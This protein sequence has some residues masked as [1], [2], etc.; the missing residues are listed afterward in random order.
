MD[1][2]G[3]HNSPQGMTVEQA[4]KLAAQTS[5][6]NEKELAKSFQLEAD[7]DGKYSLFGIEI[8]KSVA[9]ALNIIS[10][11]LI[12]SVSSGL[13]D[14]AYKQAKSAAKSFTPSHDTAHQAGIVAELV[15]RWGILFA[16]P[17]G[18]FVSAN[19]GYGRE[20]LKLRRDLK[21]DCDATGAD[22]S[23]NKVVNGVLRDASN[24]YTERLVLILPGMLSLVS[25]VPGAVISQREARAKREV[26]HA[27]TA[28]STA[29]EDVV[30]KRLTQVTDGLN[31]KLGE[32]KLKEE[33]YKLFAKNSNNKN[34]VYKILDAQY[35]ENHKDY[36]AN[37]EKYLRQWFD[38]NVWSEAL[39]HIKDENNAA[40][41]NKRTSY[42][43][44]KST[45]GNWLNQNM[46]FAG[47][48]STAGQGIKSS[49]QEEQKKKGKKPTAYALIYKLKE[50]MQGKP[51]K[52]EVHKEIMEIFQQVEEESGGVNKRFAKGLLE[53]LRDATDPVA[54]YI[55]DGRIDALSLIKLAG[56]EVV[57]DRKHNSRQFRKVEEIRKSLDEMCC[58]Q[59][60]KDN[61]ASQQE[62][63]GRFAGDQEHIKEAIKK[64]YNEMEA[65]QA[66][67]LFGAILP[68]EIL[69]KVVGLKKDDIRDLRKRA[70]EHIYKEV[71][72]SVILIA[73]QDEELLKKHGV[74]A[75]EIEAIQQ[76]S[77]RI[78]QGD[79]ESVKQM[80][81]SKDAIVSVIAA[82]GINEQ[83]EG[84]TQVW[85][86][87][88]EKGKNLDKIIEEAKQSKGKKHAGHHDREEGREDHDG[89]KPMPRS[90]KRHHEDEEMQP[91]SH[92]E[93]ASRGSLDGAEL[94]QGA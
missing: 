5:A 9:P 59:V 20:V 40:R 35:G 66:K 25:Q 2:W 28:A 3:H 36:K 75:K 6:K 33:Q 48:L 41:N 82:E 81:D 1:N 22:Y 61:E 53:T 90:R 24:R 8:P 84:K 44:D 26:E 11:A 31:L 58:T 30:K 4:Q 85:A 21:A 65:G 70:H 91:R 54:E 88:V 32:V 62:F 87:R 29:V 14:I 18:E 38:N 74:A 71:A 46:L 55:A 52:Q 47:A 12:G 80:V 77:E 79:M 92:R 39:K 60:I 83:L 69:E 76:L 49:M 15:T 7:E 93:H 56:E 73:Q 19:T 63:L 94:G 42:S 13:A 34:D 27:G 86:D 45:Q 57:I 37:G 10:D 50:H 68:I 16:K 72:A 51:S 43:E 78:L 23:H 64:T 17:I 67:D 89:E